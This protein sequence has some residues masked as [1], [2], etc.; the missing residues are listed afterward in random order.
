MRREGAMSNGVAR[1]TSSSQ[2]QGPTKRSYASATADTPLLGMTIGEAFDHTVA[3]FPDRE[4]LVAR[5]QGLRYTWAQLRIEVDR[6]ARGLMALG[7]QKGDRVGIW[8]PNRSEWTV[9]QFATAKIGAILVNIN[10]AY[11]VY[12][13]EYALNQSGC[14]TLVTA[15]AFRTTDYTAMLM[16]ICQ[17]LERSQPGELAAQRIPALRHVVRLS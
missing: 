6:C 16:E 10:P 5:A 14:M 9:T 4:A 13:L 2:A 11:R 12:E 8:A 3:R 7:V 1:G 17:E 15:P